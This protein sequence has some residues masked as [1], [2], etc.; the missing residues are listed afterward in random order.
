[1]FERV[2]GMGLW[3]MK[4]TFGLGRLFECGMRGRRV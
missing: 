4:G 2:D 3:V 1:M